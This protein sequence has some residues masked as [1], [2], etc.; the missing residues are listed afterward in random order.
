MVSLPEVPRNA[1]R[2]QAYRFINYKAMV[3]RLSPTGDKPLPESVVRELMPLQS[4]G[5]APSGSKGLGVERG[6]GQYRG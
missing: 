3:K 6:R 2:A 1:E 4:E 5:R